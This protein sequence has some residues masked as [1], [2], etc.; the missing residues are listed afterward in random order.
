MLKIAFPFS[1]VGASIWPLLP[2]MSFPFIGL[3]K[4]PTINTL[5]GVLQALDFFQLNWDF[6]WNLYNISH[7]KVTSFLDLSIK[8]TYKTCFLDFFNDNLNFWR[9]MCVILN[10]FLLV[11][12]IE[13]VL[14]VL[15]GWHFKRLIK[16]Y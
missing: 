12:L 8:F 7:F 1:F 9:I 2:S 10:I 4:L 11:N 3:V 13:F 15:D 6:W 14:R 5:I 16:Y